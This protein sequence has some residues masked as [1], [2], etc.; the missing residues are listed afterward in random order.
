[1]YRKV[2][3]AKAAAVVLRG[4]PG[5]GT[6][7]LARQAL[8]EKRTQCPCVRLNTDARLSQQAIDDV[9]MLVQYSML[10]VVLNL[11]WL[12][13]EGALLAPLFV[14]SG[15][16]LL[17]E[18]HPA[19]SSALTN[20]LER[21]GIEY[22]VV[23]VPDYLSLGDMEQVANM[24]DRQPDSV[25]PPDRKADVKKVCR[26]EN[27]PTHFRTFPHLFLSAMR[28]K[29]GRLQD[30]VRDKVDQLS[31]DPEAL[32]ALEEV[33]LVHIYARRTLPPSLLPRPTAVWGDT[34]FQLVIQPRKERGFRMISR[35]VADMFLRI[36]SNSY[37]DRAS[38]LYS[39]ASRIAA[40]HPG[41]SDVLDH[42]TKTLFVRFGH[43]R[44]L[45]KHADPLLGYEKLSELM[46][47]IAQKSPE[48][49]NN[50]FTRAAVPYRR[51]LMAA[52]LLA[53][54]AR[55]VFIR[56]L[57]KYE[58]ALKL[59]DDAIAW[60]GAGTEKAKRDR[61]LHHMR[62]DLMR[63]HLQKL[64]N[65]FL[66]SRIP[67]KE[68][69]FAPNN[70]LQQMLEVLEGCRKQL[71]VVSQIDPNVAHSFTTCVQAC[72]TVAEI[73]VHSCGSLSQFLIACAE[74]TPLASCHF[75]LFTLLPTTFDALRQMEMN[76][77]HGMDSSFE[78][79]YER[80][81]T[82]GLNDE[83]YESLL[84]FYQH[85]IPALAE[86][87]PKE[88]Q[89][90]FMVLQER[91][92]VV[93]HQHFPQKLLSHKV[94]ASLKAALAHIPP[95]TDTIGR[96]YFLYARLLD[97]GIRK[98]DI[99]FVDNWTRDQP[100]SID[101][102][103]YRMVVMFLIAMNATD[104]DERKTQL[105]KVEE[106]QLR[107]VQLNPQRAKP[108][109]MPREVLTGHADSLSSLIHLQRI[110][111]SARRLMTNP[112]MDEALLA[113]EQANPTQSSL[114]RFKIPAQSEL[115]RRGILKLEECLQIHFDIRDARIYGF[116]G[117]KPYE[118]AYG[119]I[120]EVSVVLC[121]SR[122][123]LLGLLP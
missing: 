33:A 80:L 18:V 106:C 122:R 32:Q 76:V 11:N 66:E 93:L 30:F 103:M 79:D 25:I 62:G 97:G 112:S 75:T 107:L 96:D 59:L 72:L 45:G 3:K 26:D 114:R 42:M 108:V 63:L 109:G 37:P 65:N 82:K 53:H 74:T 5:T 57:T 48:K 23:D 94:V 49:V 117:W 89:E 88:K 101:A 87:E 51:R 12:Q 19:H 77:G 16:I 31:D 90:F 24:V 100:C 41:P 56:G 44:N 83:E 35:A 39:I 121:F 119:E 38:C 8:F 47:E 6:S 99:A 17:V 36:R 67:P 116:G 73:A 46:S 120:S 4:K 118:A 1:M 34:A 27:T 86:R 70:T 60:D 29:F 50:L 43:R 84:Q 13:W 68:H 105:L 92:I 71:N 123:G 9:M 78:A 115:V 22:V 58:E 95:I 110:L 102:W 52:H 81:F 61:V 20:V 54:Q 64:A 40:K 113:F 85:R 2:K 91:A 111:Q 7:T 28:D 69:L 21:Q 10:P 98:E 104:R 14:L 55:F 15:V